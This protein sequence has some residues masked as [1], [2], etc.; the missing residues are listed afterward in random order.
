VRFGI[1]RSWPLGPILL[2]ML[3]RFTADPA[4]AW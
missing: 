1:R 4:S 2:A 3:W